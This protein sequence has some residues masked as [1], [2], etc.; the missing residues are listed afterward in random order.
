M[1]RLA[2]VTAAVAALAAGSLATTPRS[3]VAQPADPAPTDR[4][5]QIVSGTVAPPGAY[6]W[7]VYVQSGKGNCSGA[8]ISPTM[9]LTAAHCMSVYSPPTSVVVGAENVLSPPAANVF[10]VR[11]DGWFYHPSY[12]KDG[13]MSNDVAVLHLA[14]AVPPSVG[15][16]LPFATTPPP[17]S[18]GLPV[19]VMGYG[20]FKENGVY[21]GPDGK[22]RATAAE[23]RTGESAGICQRARS[24]IF[25]VYRPNHPEPVVTASGDSGGP[26]VAGTP[27]T[28]YRILGVLSGPGGISDAASTYA[29]T[30]HNREWLRAVTGSS[31]GWRATTV[32]VDPTSYYLNPRLRITGAIVD[33]NAEPHQQTRVRAKLNG[34]VVRGSEHV[35]NGW[36]PTFGSVY[37]AM[38]DYGNNR[39]VKFAPVDL[40][41]PGK[42]TVCFEYFD[43]TPAAPGKQGVSVGWK[44]AG[45]QPCTTVYAGTRPVGA[46]DSVTQVAQTST[47]RTLRVQGWAI[48]PNTPT[49]NA[50]VRVTVRPAFVGVLPPVR[51][52]WRPTSRPR[53]DVAALYPGYAATAGYTVD[54]VV[55]RN[56]ALTVELEARD[57]NATGGLVGPSFVH[58]RD[59]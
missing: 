22:L 4:A 47:T 21:Y 53:P 17:T 54:V 6:P 20:R 48:E 58:A 33:L 3:V 8:L 56:L 57:Y 35:A 9:V 18:P 2:A 36:L 37:P 26:L 59:V 45:D 1:R 19:I 5:A 38:A 29:S 32:T 23:V 42:Y 43:V 34:R 14:T 50:E 11:P 49:R 52:A 15:T 44:P 46:I 10:A 24:P 31:G 25:C 40:P 16:P 51:T 27:A 39:G 12:Y 55:P 41:R 28:G 13:G 7:M 30:F